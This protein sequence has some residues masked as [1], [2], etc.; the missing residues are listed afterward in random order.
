MSIPF[1][2]MLDPEKYGYKQC[3]RC[4]GYGSSLKES[5]N[6]CSKCGGIGLV[7]K[8]KKEKTDK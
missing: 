2:V 4:D 5:G 8:E 7:K 1:E 3:D 6:T